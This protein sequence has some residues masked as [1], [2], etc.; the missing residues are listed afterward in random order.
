MRT[1]KSAAVLGA[2]VIEAIELARRHAR[3]VIGMVGSSDVP[4]GYEL[5]DAYRAELASR[6]PEA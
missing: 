4:E 1:L 3:E 2:V 5:A 6:I